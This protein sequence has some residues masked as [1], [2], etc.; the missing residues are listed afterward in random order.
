[1]EKAEHTPAPT[2]NSCY[3]SAAQWPE[4]LNF[5]QKLGYLFFA[6]FIL[7]KSIYTKKRSF[8]YEMFKT[9]IWAKV[10]LNRI[11]NFIDFESK[12]GFYFWPQ[13]GN[14]GH[15]VRVCAVHCV[16]FLRKG[17]QL[18]LLPTAL[19]AMPHCCVRCAELPDSI[20]KTFL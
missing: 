20:M 6:I 14:S 13:L 2:H 1:M 7:N 15:C 18:L 9:C 19:G 16:R 17:T 11:L 4:F 12:N 10:Y 8:L 5:V 3:S